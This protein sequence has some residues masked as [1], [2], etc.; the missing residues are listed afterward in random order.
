MTPVT[1]ALPV[2]YERHIVGDI[3]IS[4]EGPSFRYRP[5]WLKTAG[6][7]PVSSLMPVAHD[8][9]CPDIFVPWTE[10]LLPES[11]NLKTIGRNL[12]IAP[13]DIIGILMKIG[14]DTA[15]ALSIGMPGTPD[16]HDWRRIET[17]HDLATIIDELPKK[18][19][20]AGDEGVSISLAGVQN[21]MAVGR[22][23]DGRLYIPLNGSPSTHIL[24]PDSLDHLHGSVQNE[25]LCLTLATL[26]GLNAV[27][28]TTGVAEGRTY[29]LVTRYDRRHQDDLW[30]RLHQEDFCQILGKPPAAKY[31][32]NQSGIKGPT[33][34]DMVEAT[35]VLMSPVDVLMLVDY[36]IFNLLVGNIDAHAKNYSA[37]ITATRTSLAPLY[38]V[39]HAQ[40]W[41]VTQNMAQTV[42]G[43]NRA[44]HIKGRHWQRMARECGLNPPALLARITALANLVLKQVVRAEA[45]VMAMPAGGHPML[46]LFRTGIEN[47]A[48]RVLSNLA[49][50]Q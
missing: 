7:F 12:G 48:R 4:H 36:F 40:A 9:Y 10:N 1:T 31:E 14:R 29:L 21:K 18:P 41:E 22:D 37:L 16:I 19:F 24:K 8:S 44:D 2:Y 23:E 25:A 6:A 39:M 35:R 42:D 46:A 3:H 33:F 26:C 5:E 45:E 30:R 43:K 50:T 28:I 13:Q 17:T 38:D 15:G 32:N 27:K 34:K 49:E 20:L 47:R 11:T